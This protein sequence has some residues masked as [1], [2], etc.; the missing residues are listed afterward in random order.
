MPP[1]AGDSRIPLRAMNI[2]IFQRIAKRLGTTVAAWGHAKT[3]QSQGQGAR[4]GAARRELADHPCAGGCLY[5]YLT[6]EGRHNGAL[7]MDGR[8]TQGRVD[9]ETDFGVAP[10]PAGV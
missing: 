6:C 2:L 9:D 8:L 7:M 5:P 3:A 10:L 4:T 1:P